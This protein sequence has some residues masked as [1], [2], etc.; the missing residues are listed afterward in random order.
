MKKLPLR[1]MAGI[2]YILFAA[3]LLIA[4][5]NRLAGAIFLGIGIYGWIVTF[6]KQDE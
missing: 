3:F 4:G 1:K 5:P 2:A 6:G